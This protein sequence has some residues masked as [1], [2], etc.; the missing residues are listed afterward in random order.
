MFNLTLSLLKVYSLV[1]PITN[2]L[3]GKSSILQVF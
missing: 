2:M 1:T 3:N